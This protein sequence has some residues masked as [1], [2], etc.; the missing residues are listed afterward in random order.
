MFDAG[1]SETPAADCPGARAPCGCLFLLRLVGPSASDALS[2]DDRGS[3]IGLGHARWRARWCPSCGGRVGIFR[4]ELVLAWRRF[5]AARERHAPALELRERD[6]VAVYCAANGF[7]TLEGEGYSAQARS[8]TDQAELGCAWDPDH[9]RWYPWLSF[10]PPAS[11]AR[12]PF[13][14]GSLDD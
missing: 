13:V 11:L 4:P 7:G 14:P 8:P 3:W 6:D 10:A 2:T 1:F 5:L 9:E 12:D